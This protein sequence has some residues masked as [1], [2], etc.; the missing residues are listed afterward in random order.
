MMVR[1]GRFVMGMSG[2]N[3][4]QV[5]RSCIYCGSRTLRQGELCQREEHIGMC[6][7][8]LFIIVAKKQRFILAHSFRG[9]SSQLAGSMALDLRPPDY[10]GGGR[11]GRVLT[12]FMAARKYREK[13]KKWPGSSS[14]A[15]PPT[16]SSF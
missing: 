3:Q 12:H 9:F 13:E 15:P 5:H 14:Q 16:L 10:H 1:G 4:G 11:T 2:E 7:S 8:G 6:Y